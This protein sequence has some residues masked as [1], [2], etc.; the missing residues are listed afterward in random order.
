MT[1]DIDID[2]DA[3]GVG[4]GEAVGA[5]VTD[6]YVCTSRPP[7]IASAFARHP[8]VRHRRRRRR[9][10][11][12]QPTQGTE[13]CI[14]EVGELEDAGFGF[15]Q[16]H[17]IVIMCFGTERIQFVGPSDSLYGVYGVRAAMVASTTTTRN[18][19][20]ND[21]R[22]TQHVGHS[23]NNNDSDN[24]KIYM[25]FLL[26]HLLFISSYTPGPIHTLVLFREQPCSSLAKSCGGKG[27][28]DI[29]NWKSSMQD[30]DTHYPSDD[31]L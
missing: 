5:K 18:S 14:V 9:E 21:A 8:T 6:T 12:M 26:L 23:N 4:V 28:T 15:E 20:E 22:T 30:D 17:T 1:S 29:S 27:E 16:I 25:R 2:G 10:D 13:L 31:R 24:T 19:A 11:L 3:D 7:I